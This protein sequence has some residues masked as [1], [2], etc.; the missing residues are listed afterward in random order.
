MPERSPSSAEEAEGRYGDPAHGE[1]LFSSETTRSAI[2]TIVDEDYDAAEGLAKLDPDQVAPGDIVK[3]RFGLGFWIAIGWLALISGLAALANVL[4]LRPPDEIPRT[5]VKTDKNLPPL[6]T[7][8][9]DNFYLLGTDNLGRDMLSRVIYGARVSLIV[10]L[11]A[12]VFGLLVGGALGLAAGYFRGR[13]DSVIVAIAGIIIAYPALVLAMALVQ[14]LLR[15]GEVG[16]SPS[17][18]KSVM[19]VALAIGIPS[20]GPLAILVRSSTLQFS[21]REFVLASR[22]LG[23]GHTRVMIREILPNVILPVISF[24]FL[25]VGLAI[26]AEGG[27]SFFGLS[28]PPPTPTW[29]VMIQEGQTSLQAG[30]WWVPMIP[31]T[32]LVLTILCLNLAGDRLRRFFNV[33]ESLL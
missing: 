33:K 19:V 5:F 26:V 14:V 9:Q 32:F 22:T 24:A 2:T 10:G 12:V 30:A 13:T 6:S 4:P 21:Q 3:K 1:L 8:S 17:L 28:V 11:V 27:L 16:D 15:S 29:G 23:A 20:I 25:G 31:I 7:N 18:T